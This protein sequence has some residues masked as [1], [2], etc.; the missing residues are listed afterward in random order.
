M[1]ELCI[2]HDQLVGVTDLARKFLGVLFIL[3]HFGKPPVKQGELEPWSSQLRQLARLPNVSCKVSGLTTEADWEQ[4]TAADLKPYFET[5]LES[6]GPNRV[7]F[8]GDWP[9]CTLA[10]EYQRW[11]GTVAELTSLL[12]AEDSAKLFCSNA[13]RIYRI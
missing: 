6:F 2:R 5:V 11:V 3:D 4:W 13:E 8:A 12:S 10:T 9:V 1:F 7:I